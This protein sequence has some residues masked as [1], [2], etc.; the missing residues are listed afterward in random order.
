MDN[1]LMTIMIIG[2]T[3]INI[4]CCIATCGVGVYAWLELKSFMKST[5]KVEFVPFDPLEQELERK[6]FKD[7]KVQQPREPMVDDIFNDYGMTGN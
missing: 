1:Q 5:H 6:K 4:I 3:I 7:N 2:L